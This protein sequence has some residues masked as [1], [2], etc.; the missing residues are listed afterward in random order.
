MLM[1]YWVGSSIEK[2]LVNGFETYEITILYIMSQLLEIPTPS[3]SGL[4]G[5]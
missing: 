4:A 1:D 3:E 2:I 5:A